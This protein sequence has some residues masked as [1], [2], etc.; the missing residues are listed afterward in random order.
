MGL[1]FSV[2]TIVPLLLL[3]FSCPGDDAGAVPFTVLDACL[4]VPTPQEQ[5]FRNAEDWRQFYAEHTDGGTA[6]AVDFGR[7]VLAARFDGAGSA[8]VGFTV[9]S[10]EQKDGRVTIKATR[11]TST[12]PC[13]D[14][15]AYPQLIVVVERRDRPVTFEIRDVTGPPPAG[16]RPCV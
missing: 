10:V 11:H 3:T 4:R 8:C 2:V 12:G 14:V 1:G 15:V 9:E 6:P 13:I 16:H 7:S 5:L